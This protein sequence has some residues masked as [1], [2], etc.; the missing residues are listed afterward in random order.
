M[1]KLFGNK[2]IYFESGFI[3]F[4]LIIVSIGYS[5]IA[6]QSHNHFETFG[7]DLGFFD[8]IIWKASRGDLVALS[9][10]NF[11]NLL[12]D[13]FQPVLYILSPLYLIKSDVRMILIAQAFLVVL[14]SYP[15]YLL[16]KEKSRNIIFSFSIVITYLF[17]I[18]TQWLILNEFHQMAF[19]PLILISVF[20]SLHKKNKLGYWISIVGLLFIKEE[21]ALLV[22]ALG[23]VVLTKYKWK[24]EGL[25]TIFVGIFS[26]FFLIYLFMPYLSVKGEYSH[27][28]FGDAGFTPTDVIQKSVTNPEFFLNSMLNPTVKIKTVFETFF[29]FGFLPFLSPLYLL[30]VL[31]NFITRF[32]YAGPQFTKWINV[33]QHAAPLGILMSVATIYSSTRLVAFLSKRNKFNKKKLWTILGI[34]IFCI[35]LFQDFI[36]HGPFNSI[37]KRQLYETKD[38][39]KDNYLVISEIPPNVS[40]AAQNSLLPH[41]SQR[42]KVYLLPEIYDAE[43]ILIDLYDGQ[44]KYSPVNYEE[45]KLLINNLLLSE[46]YSIYFQKGK[47]MLLKR[48]NFASPASK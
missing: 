36:L 24:K 21:V 2:K 10:L 9:T 23:L 19:L 40:I 48:S 20:Y 45:M 42:N 46:K 30:P 29:A 17:F 22:S 28:G 39:M 33:N 47:A 15:L 4:F 18:G 1:F 8:Q 12:A 37:L 41:V 7:W 11:E 34:Y 43:Y 13:H 44:N 31:E 14:A 32:I 3:I 16:A 35:A 27:M 5:I 25:I 26:F 6:V 38:W